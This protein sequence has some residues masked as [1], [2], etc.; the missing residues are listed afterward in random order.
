MRRLGK[1]G[2]TAL[3]VVVGGIVSGGCTDM[4]G[5]SPGPWMRGAVRANPGKYTYDQANAIFSLSEKLDER[6]AHQSR[7]DA[8]NA[9]RSQVNIH[10]GGNGGHRAFIPQGRALVCNA[11]V[12]SD[13]DGMTQL[14]ELEGRHKR[15]FYDDEVFTLVLGSLPGRSGNVSLTFHDVRTGESVGPAIV[16]DID[17]PNTFY[18]LEINPVGVISPGPYIYVWTLDDGSEVD[19]ISIRIRERR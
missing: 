15:A 14:D 3:A 13:G 4:F 19:R 6:A 2:S 9:A 16:S 11:L 10:G 1:S 18:Y 17:G 7:M 8:A 5:G 12:D